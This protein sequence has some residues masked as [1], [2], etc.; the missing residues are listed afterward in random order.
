MFLGIIR[1][2]EAAAL[3]DLDIWEQNIATSTVLF[4]FIE[5]SK[6]YQGREGHT[7]VLEAAPGS[8]LC[9]VM[10]FR[11]FHTLSPAGSS[12]FLPFRQFFKV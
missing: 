3:G 5:K 8:L 6:T 10:W 4:I 1:E 12:L 2:S 9:P 7:V 11:A